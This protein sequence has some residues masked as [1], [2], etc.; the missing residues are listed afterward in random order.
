M[1]LFEPGFWAQIDNIL[2]A[3]EQTHGAIIK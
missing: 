1:V 2:A 3:E